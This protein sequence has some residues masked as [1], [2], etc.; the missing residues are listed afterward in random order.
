[1]PY[2]VNDGWVSDTRQYHIRVK[3]EGTTA[4]STKIEVRTRANDEDE[5]GGWEDYEAPADITFTNYYGIPFEF[6]KTGGTDPGGNTIY[7][8]GVEFILYKCSKPA[9]TSWQHHD[10]F[11]PDNEDACWVFYDEAV[12][13]AGTGQVTFDLL[14]NGVYCMA[15]VK[16]N[17]TYQLPFGQ[18]LIT[19]NV[20]AP[21]PAD[22]IKIGNF[23]AQMPPA[24][25]IEPDNSLSVANYKQFITPRTGSITGLLF[26]A[27]GTALVSLAAFFGVTTRRKRKKLSE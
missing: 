7:L 12:S 4:L 15:E 18:W 25:K 1:V 17:P 20:G 16:T 5:W 10:E 23:G 14:I 8:G 3:V 24:F 6:R 9:H 22:R 21:N 13:A 27:G 11:D 2:T 26:S 19:V